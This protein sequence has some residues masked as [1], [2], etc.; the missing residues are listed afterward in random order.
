M[1]AQEKSNL[2]VIVDCWATIEAYADLLSLVSVSRTCHALHNLVVVDGKIKCSKVVVKDTIRD[3]AGN[4]HIDPSS[5][6]AK[7]DDY[8]PKLLSHLDFPSL[9]RLGIDFP[10]NITTW[11]SNR[12]QSVS[13]F[14][15]AFPILATQ[16]ENANNMEDLSMTV[17]NMIPSE[18][19]MGNFRPIYEIFGDN[20]SK[21]VRRSRKLKRLTISNIFDPVD[22]RGFKHYYYS[23]A[24]LAAMVP[25]IKASIFT[26]EEVHIVLGDR[27]IRNNECPYAARD[28]FRAILS[29]QKLKSLK[30]KMW[31]VFGT[32]LNDFVDA[33]RDVLADLN[34]LP[35]ES[36][37][38]IEMEVPHGPVDARPSFSPCFSLFSTAPCLRQLKLHLPQE[39]FDK[40]GI[41]MLSNYLSNL[42]MLNYLSVNFHGYKDRS[43]AILEFLRRF[44]DEKVPS[45]EI[46]VQFNRMGG[47]VEQTL[48]FKALGDD[49]KSKSSSTF[50]YVKHI[51]EDDETLWDFKYPEEEET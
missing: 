18:R 4:S 23:S 15:V 7:I 17:N 22:R 20:F 28:F 29:L 49:A 1:S 35:S 39:A 44:V 30:I 40:R 51:L 13:A 9:N 3:N 37:E 42:P 21:C 8:L 24:F 16:I 27:P 31:S 14:P 6:S 10:R 45:P 12:V 36:L 38:C 19:T 48:S 34:R 11:N 46:Y 47:L 5:P 25:V 32:T 41:A 33:S 43:G 26:L 2:D 50:D